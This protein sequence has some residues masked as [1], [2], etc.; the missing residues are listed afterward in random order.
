LSFVRV[1][2]ILAF[3]VPAAFAHSQQSQPADGHAQS[4][5]SQSSEAQDSEPENPQPQSDKS[6]TAKDDPNQEKSDDQV[7]KSKL[8]RE[9]GTVN[10]RIFEVPPNYGTVETVRCAILSVF[11][12]RWHKA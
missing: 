6:K 8:E 9:T 12:K 10:D 2:A 11:L 1:F 3:L 4:P 5:Q 7:G